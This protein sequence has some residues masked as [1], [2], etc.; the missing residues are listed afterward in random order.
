MKITLGQLHTHPNM[1]KLR[2]ILN[3]KTIEEK[4]DLKLTQFYLRCKF[5][6]PKYFQ[7]VNWQ[8]YKKYI[9]HKRLMYSTYD[10]SLRKIT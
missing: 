6:P 4:I 7:Y 1:Y 5:A 8:T 9:K 3:A 10:K 2:K